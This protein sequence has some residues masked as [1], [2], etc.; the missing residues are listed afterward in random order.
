MKALVGA[1]NQEKPLVGA[2]SVIVQPVVKPMDR[3]AALLS[4]QIHLFG[5]TYYLDILLDASPQDACSQISPKDCALT[6]GVTYFLSA[7]LSL[8][9][10]NLIGRRVLMLISLLGEIQRI[11]GMVLK[12][13]NISIY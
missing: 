2:F 9:L 10:K 7:L 6:I 1:F 12:E 5:P 3:I 13:K 11:I 4:P 8:V